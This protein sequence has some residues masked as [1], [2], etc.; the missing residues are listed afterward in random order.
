MTDQPP[1][2]PS[3]PSRAERSERRPSKGERT[4][5]RI[6]D[7]AT[8]LFSKSG[9]RAV[10]L[11]DIAAHAG[12]THAGLLHHFPG[13]EELLVKVLNRRERTDAKLL[14]SVEPETRPDELLDVLVN[15][16]VRNTRTP[17]LVALYVKISGEAADP[18]HPAHAYFVERYRVLRGLATELFAELFARSSPRLEH[19][20][21]AVAQQFLALMDGLQT[22]WLLEPDVVD[23]PASVNAFLTQLGL[24]PAPASGRAEP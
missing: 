23:M 21:A 3:P 7:S 20:P 14:F 22:Q 17:G 2:P 9:F 11:R 4:R 13:K 18:E 8:E 10:S 24:D 16:V 5:A 12:L 6:L 15:F 1:Q 19:D